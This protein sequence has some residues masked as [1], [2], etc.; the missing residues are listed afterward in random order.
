MIE[1]GKASTV[2]FMK[3]RNSLVVRCRERKK[4]EHGEN[5][6]FNALSSRFWLTSKSCSWFNK[7][8]HGQ[9]SIKWTS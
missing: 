1:I 7:V 2:T 3:A 4:T 8:V 6:F 5:V 9:P